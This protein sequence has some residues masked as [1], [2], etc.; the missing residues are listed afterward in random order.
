MAQSCRKR[1]SILLYEHAHV[2]IPPEWRRGDGNTVWNATKTI[3]GVK[4]GAL[5]QQERTLVNFGA[6]KSVW[7]GP[8]TQRG[9]SPSHS[10]E[11]CNRRASL[12][13]DSVSNETH[14]LHSFPFFLDQKRSFRGEQLTGGLRLRGGFRA[15]L[16]R[17][18]N[19]IIDLSL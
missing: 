18:I 12:R 6:V 13:A 9:T 16:Q 10:C 2:L 19:E 5:V 17:A 8:A 11:T 7:L 15:R 4:Y 3:L 14:S 1:G